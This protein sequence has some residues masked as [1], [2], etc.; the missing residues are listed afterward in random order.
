MENFEIN[1]FWKDELGDNLIKILDRN[2]GR[3]GNYKFRYTELYIP[4]GFKY[5]KV[6]YTHNNKTNTLLAFKVLFCLY[7]GFNNIFVVQLPNGEIKY[8]ENFLKDK[9]IFET[10]NDFFLFIEGETEKGILCTYKPFSKLPFYT[11]AYSGE[12]NIIQSWTWNLK[13]EVVK[14]RTFIEYIMFNE[15]GLNFILNLRNDEYKTKSECIKS[16]LNGMVIE[17]FNTTEIKIDITITKNIST[18]IIRTL[19]FIEK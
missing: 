2:K 13:S 18:P 19:T 3:Y 10:P 14:T 5:N 16:K 11:I 12:F 4:C 9:Y 8:I 15:D 1:K 17:D 7:S 6:Y